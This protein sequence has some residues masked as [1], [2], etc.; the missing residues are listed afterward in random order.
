MNEKFPFLRDLD[1]AKPDEVLENGN[2]VFS[3]RCR[4]PFSAPSESFVLRRAQ[5]EMEERV[6]IDS[7]EGEK[8][9]PSA[10]GNPNRDEVNFADPQTIIEGTASSTSVDFYGTEMSKDALDQMAMQMRSGIPY[11][12]KHNN[13][14]NGPM[15]WF[16]TMGRTIDAT[17]DR[18]DEVRAA[19]NSNEEQY[20]LRAKIALYPDEPH[21][22]A[23]LRR[24]NRGEKIG[25]SI[26]GWFTE[27]QFVQNND[28]EIERV[29][30]RGIELDHLAATRAPANPDSNDLV[31]L[32]SAVRSILTE[33]P[34]PQPEVEVAVEVEPVAEDLHV[35]S[36]E[37]PVVL[38]AQE[39]SKG[40]P[41]HARH[42]LE[43][44]EDDTAIWIKFAKE[45]EEM[46]EQD[47]PTAEEPMPV[48]APAPA[49]APVEESAIV[50][51]NDAGESTQ[52]PD[53]ALDIAALSALLDSKLAPLAERIAKV[54]A[55][56]AEPV[57]TP[58]ATPEQVRIAELEAQLSALT[59][60]P[61]RV[62][63]SAA[64]L[65]VAPVAPVNPKLDAAREQAPNVARAVET[66]GSSLQLRGDKSPTNTADQLAAL[67]NA[68]E[69]D[70][71]LSKTFN[72]ANWA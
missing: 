47:D 43:V 42:I 66:L 28:K 31:S 11:L 60:Q 40:I 10:S 26:G 15:E 61:H 25:Q 44:L 39:L 34:A 2:K 55:G 4:V 19:F 53:M 52:E 35:A 41:P 38:E 49:Q 14:A 9:D 72:R 69:A 50:S 51:G 67:L 17:V 3:V 56:N 13:G 58:T 24:L 70:G 32:R 71:I 37:V 63:R 29:I 57:V 6:T 45:C 33:L 64:A 20:V 5:P 68:A 30:V 54:E 1:V 27:L 62:G 8:L 65:P 16:E 48:E 7:G 21:A 22:Q 23:M 12:P 18:V 36:A 59:S 46:P